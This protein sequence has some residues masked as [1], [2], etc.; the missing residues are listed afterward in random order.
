MRDKRKRQRHGL[1]CVVRY[2]TED[3]PNR[4]VTTK[5]VDI[6]LGGIGVRVREFIKSNMK[7]K[8]KIY[9]QL[10]TVPIDAEGKVVWQS[11]YPGFGAHRAGIQF[12]DAPYTKIKSLINEA[13][14]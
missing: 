9:S 5:A 7:I 1:K 6:S 12:T 3:Y 10:S 2:L 11:G 14:G 8:L 13:A 4:P